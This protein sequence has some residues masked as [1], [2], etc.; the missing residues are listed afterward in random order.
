MPDEADSEGDP[1][2][3]LQAADLMAPYGRWPVMVYNIESGGLAIQ[4]CHTSAEGLGWYAL[5]MRMLRSAKQH[6]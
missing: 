4:W 5:E 6:G 3:A 2:D 1:G